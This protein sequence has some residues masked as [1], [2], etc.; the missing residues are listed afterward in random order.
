MV[1]ILKKQKQSNNENNILIKKFYSTSIFKVKNSHPAIYT[2]FRDENGNDFVGISNLTSSSI[3]QGKPTIPVGFK[4]NGKE[5]FFVDKID[6]IPLYNN[7]SKVQE[8]SN[9]LLKANDKFSFELSPINEQK[10][11]QCVKTTFLKKGLGEITYNYGQVPPKEMK[12]LI[13]SCKKDSLNI[14]E[15][16]TLKKD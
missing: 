16:I 14:L 11:L 2:N 15:N 5:S 7:N 6:I 3:V 12:E 13:D 4:Q 10:I 1:P 9:M 8:L